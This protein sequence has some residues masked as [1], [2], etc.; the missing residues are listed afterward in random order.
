MRG[1]SRLRSTKLL[2][3]AGLHI[4]DKVFK[5]PPLVASLLNLGAQL[6]CGFRCGHFCR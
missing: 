2:S 3:Q 1:I 6:S 4:F 5:A